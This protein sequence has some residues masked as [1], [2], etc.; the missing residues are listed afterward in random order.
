MRQQMFAFTWLHWGGEVCF[1]RE[2]AGD[3]RQHVGESH[4]KDHRKGWRKAYR[5]GARVV[6][7]WVTTTPPKP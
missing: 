4:D 5:R 6:R 1:V 3:I 7:V 2:R